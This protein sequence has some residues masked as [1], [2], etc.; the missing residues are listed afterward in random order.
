[1]TAVM[2]F[3]MKNSVLPIIPDSIYEARFNFFPY[4]ASHILL[5]IKYHTAKTAIFPNV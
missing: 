3:N 4:Y 5:L 2:E 1:M